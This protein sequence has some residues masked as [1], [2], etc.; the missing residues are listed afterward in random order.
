M[1]TTYL[2]HWQKLMV[3]KKII[4]H[5][6]VVLIKNDLNRKFGFVNICKGQKS[7][8][9]GF[10]KKNYTLSKILRKIRNI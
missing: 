4:K 9:I 10:N 6:L 5:K 8:K 2:M 3:D 7:Y 1:V